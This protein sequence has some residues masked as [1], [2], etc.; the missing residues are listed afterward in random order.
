MSSPIATH[1]LSKAFRHTEAVNALD[2]DVPEG[3][4]YALI[5][6]NGAGKTTTIKLLMNIL[7]ASAGS[8]EVLGVD[9][10]RLSPAEFARIGYVS[11]NQEIPEWMTVDYFLRYLRPFYPAWDDA[12]ADDMVRQFELPRDRKLRH[13]SRG[14]RM[15]AALASS[16]AYRPELIVL[17]EPFTGLDALVRD[18]FTRSL[19]D[20]AEGTTILISSHDLAEI[21]SFASHIGYLGGGRLQ[22]SEELEALGARFREIALTFE[23]A[24]ALPPEWPANWQRPETAGPVV[25]FVET[26]FDEQRT[27]AEARRLFPGFRDMAV[28]AIPLRSIFV[29]LAK[30]SRDRRP[31]D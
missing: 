14:M 28:N 2:L 23:T 9:S 12:L 15:K 26:Q 29:S 19:L 6:P 13:L 11:E 27:A 22:F 1:N 24:P 31:R 16:L 20:R 25:R 17:D 7:R 21:E 4:I 3:S 8:A 5:G 18:E 10:R 30:A